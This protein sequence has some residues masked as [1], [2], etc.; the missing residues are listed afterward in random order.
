MVAIYNYTNF[1]IV[2][3]DLSGSI[4]NNKDFQSLTDPWLQLYSLKNYFEFEF[5][6]KNLGFVNPIYCLHAAI[7]IK[8]I[9]KQKLKYLLKSKI[10]VYNKY[11][12]RLAKYIFYIERPVATVEIILINDNNSQITE[13]YNP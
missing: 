12:F 4:I 11:I 9:K 2:K 10:Y 6:T 3:V 13:Y 1:P 5:D 7:F 8:S